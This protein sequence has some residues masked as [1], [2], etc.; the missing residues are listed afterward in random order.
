MESKIHVLLVT[1]A[2]GGVA[3]HIE[4]ILR[5]ASDRFEF[6]LVAPPSLLVEDAHKLGISVVEYDFKREINLFSDLAATIFLMR[7]CREH[8]YDIYHYHSSKAGAYGRI[9]AILI[10]KSEKT[11]YT[12]N[13]ISLIGF[14]GMKARFFYWLERAL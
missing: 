6:T 9:V 2:L 13:A 3:T 7:W 4:H 14:R 5:F 1:Q 10:G 12:P 8:Q 11:L